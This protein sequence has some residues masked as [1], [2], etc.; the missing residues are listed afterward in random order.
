[1]ILGNPNISNRF[2]YISGV[3][4][5]LPA[6]EKP[7]LGERENKGDERVTPDGRSAAQAGDRLH[8]QQPAAHEVVVPR[9]VLRHLGH[10]P[11]GEAALGADLA[12]GVGRGPLRPD[13]GMP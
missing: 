12:G 6:E 9:A 3:Y 13:Q 7:C 11:L 8:G 10:P 2:V 5:S 4:G 1:M